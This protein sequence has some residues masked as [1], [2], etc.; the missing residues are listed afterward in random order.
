[1]TIAMGD[2]LFEEFLKGLNKGLLF[3]DS[4]IY[5]QFSIYNDYVN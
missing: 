2:Y 1:M 5:T 4:N 3:K